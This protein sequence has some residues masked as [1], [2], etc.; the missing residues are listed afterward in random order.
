MTVASTLPIGLIRPGGQKTV[1]FTD[2]QQNLFANQQLDYDA[3]GWV[4][5]AHTA[6]ASSFQARKRK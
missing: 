2:T 5:Q 4:G 3:A 1:G 6:L